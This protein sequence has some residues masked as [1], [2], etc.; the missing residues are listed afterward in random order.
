MHRK[1]HVDTLVLIPTF[2]IYVFSYSRQ[3]DRQTEKFIPVWASL[4]TF[5][6][7]NQGVHVE[8]SVHRPSPPNIYS[9]VREENSGS[10]R[11]FI[12]I[13]LLFELH[14]VYVYYQPNSCTTHSEREWAGGTF[15][16]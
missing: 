11:K 3:T 6:Q 1:L 5:L 8:F 13:Y 7:V 14:I 2:K 15:L 12:E 4:T 10:T 16:R 9:Y